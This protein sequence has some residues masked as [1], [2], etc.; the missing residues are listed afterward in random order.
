MVS[1]HCQF[2]SSSSC[3]LVGRG[4]IFKI[5]VHPNTPSIFPLHSTAENVIS[6]KIKMTMERTSTN[7]EV[8]MG[9]K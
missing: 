4:F 5:S 6:K 9:N 7:Y 8:A 1:I 3:L 2:L